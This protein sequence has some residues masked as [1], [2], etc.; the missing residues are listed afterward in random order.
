MLFVNENAQWI[1]RQDTAC[2]STSAFVLPLRQCQ[3][4]SVNALH[5]NDGYRNTLI[6]AGVLAQLSSVISLAGCPRLLDISEVI[7]L[8]TREKYSLK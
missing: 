4:R 8:T 1:N 7:A 6:D 2:Y 3:L 5:Y